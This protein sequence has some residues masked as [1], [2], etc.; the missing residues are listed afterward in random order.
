MRSNICIKTLLGSLTSLLLL[1]STSALAVGDFNL[2]WKNRTDRDPTTWNSADYKN[3]AFVVEVYQL[4]CPPCNT[5]AA[6]INNIAATYANNSKVQV[7]ST[8]LDQDE[9]SYKQWIMR[10]SPNH[11]VLMDENRTL[12]RQL[13]VTVTPTTFVLDCNKNVKWQHS[14][15]LT[16]DNINEIKST[17]NSLSG[18]RCE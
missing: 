10:H 1:A 18:Q 9:T 14:G 11:P 3:S 16:S 6:N 5:N 8:G 2:P 13:G 17:I 7:I 4:R 15:V 12:S